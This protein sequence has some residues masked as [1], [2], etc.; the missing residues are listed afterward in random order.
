MDTP[1]RSSVRG[2]ACML[3]MPRLPEKF[4]HA[5]AAV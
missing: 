2:A 1:Y 5:R 4:Y 3:L